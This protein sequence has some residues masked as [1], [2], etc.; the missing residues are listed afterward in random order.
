MR[1]IAIIALAAAALA[2]C[3]E[4]ERLPKVGGNWD[5]PYT[6]DAPISDPC[7]VTDYGAGVFYFDC[8]KAFPIALAWWRE[9]HPGPVSVAP[10]DIAGHGYTSGY[11]VVL[12]QP[13]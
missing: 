13:Q 1:K 11:F 2:S 9:R 10:L 12:E 5:A 6:P 8:V 7:L 3:T 4:E